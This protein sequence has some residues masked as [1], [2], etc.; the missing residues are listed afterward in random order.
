MNRLRA[1]TLMEMMVVMVV[2][3][4]AITICFTC[5]NLIQ[6]QFLRFKDRQEAFAVHLEIDRL[7]T[8]DFSDCR[9]IL[10]MQQG[11]SFRYAWRTVRYEFMDGMIV[12]LDSARS[13]TFSIPFSGIEMRQGGRDVVEEGEMIDA[14]RLQFLIDDEEF[15]LSFQKQ[16]GADSWLHDHRSN[17]YIHGID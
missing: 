13:D 5:F 12:R 2:S 7:M 17:D 10:K 3:A 6:R 16:Y 15:S 11:C 1:F 4:V 9:Q 14:L 8:K